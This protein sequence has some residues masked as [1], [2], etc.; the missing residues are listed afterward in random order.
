MKRFIF[1][2][3]LLWLIV[4]FG[5]CARAQMFRVDP[6]SVTTTS[7]SAPIG[8]YPTLYA[9]PGSQVSICT[10]AACTLPATTYTSFTGAVACPVNAQVTLAGS[11]VCT[12]FTG[13]QGQFGFFLAANSGGYW[14]TITVPNGTR[15]GPYPLSPSNTAGVTNLAAGT[16]ISIS[17]STGSITV[18]NAGVTSLGGSTGALNLSGGSGISI[19]GLTVTNT[20][21]TSLDGSA[22]ALNLVAGAGISVSG[23]SISN[24]GVV[25]FN[26]RTGAVSP[27]AGDYAVSTGGTGATGFSSNGLLYG[28]GSAPIQATT[29]GLTYQVAQVSGS[30]APVF[31]SVQLA[32]SAAVSGVLANAN[33]GTG[34]GGALVGIVR[35]GYPFTAAELSGD[36]STFASNVVTLATVNSTPTSCGTATTTCVLTVNAKG[37]VTASSSVAITGGGGGIVSPSTNGAAFWNGTSLTTTPTGGTGTLCLV[38]TNGGAPTFGACSGSAST[39]WS[40]LTAPSSNLSVSMGAYSTTFTW[41]SSTSSNNLFNLTDGSSNTGTGYM[42]DVNLSSGSAMSPALFA[43]NGNG[44]AVNNSG[45]IVV[46]GTGGIPA[47]TIISGVIAPAR[48]LTAA[49]TNGIGYYDG[50][51]FTTTATGGAG[52]LCLVSVGGATP[53]FSSCAGSASTAWS[54]L[55]NPTGAMSVSMGSNT[56]T[57]T[58]GAATSTANLFN[59]TDT[60]SNTG[61]GYIFSVN[62]ASGSAAAP[63]RF[64]V[65]GNGIAINNSGNIVALGTGGDWNGAVIGSSYGGAGTVHGIMQANGSGVVSAVTI[66]TGLT[67]S[68]GTLS[69]SGT[70]GV[71]GSNT[72]VQ[73]NNSGSCGASST[74][75]Y[76][77][78]TDYLGI[79]TGAS[80]SG[81]TIDRSTVTN[82]SQIQWTVSGNGNAS[83]AWLVGNDLSGLFGITAGNT[84]L[85]GLK[86]D[87]GGAV[88]VSTGS[89]NGQLSIDRAS[90]SYTGEILFTSAGSAY[91]NAG[92]IAFGTSQ[93]VLN[94]LNSNTSSGPLIVDGNGITVNPS[95]VVGQGS[96]YLA[97]LTIVQSG[98]PNADFLDLKYGS[99]VN[100]KIDSNGGLTAYNCCIASQSNPTRVAGTIYHNTSGKPL[101][102][103][104]TVSGVGS[105]SLCRFYTDSSSS[106]T[107]DVVEVVTPI[108]GGEVP[109]TFIVLPGN[110][111]RSDAL[112]EFSITVWTEWQ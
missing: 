3:L 80:N 23:L 46:V 54:A 20:G 29:A 90:P 50:T 66:G 112:G 28:N 56:S 19:S 104:I 98:V 68:G 109:V 45:D 85:E 32:Q 73:Y 9:V 58:Y 111:Y 10:D 107:T 86:V 5:P 22:G 42:L 64:A 61:T 48:L 53:S 71:C 77:T 15:Y 75:T 67:L 102:V 43:V 49:N 8:S 84:N 65:N 92:N 108:G 94:P 44:V 6:Q 55:S 38:S 103:T 110:Y 7:G 96:A 105:G 72:Q 99:T 16:G 27:Q 24:T 33:G 26:G 17:S 51:H 37:L 31:G 69:T 101:F 41:N 83:G 13:P 14:Y 39:A 60:S 47:A 89:T 93:F 88:Y 21:V 35:G 34:T 95:I 36:A 79:G 59:L 70:S 62:L 52:T 106:P 87:S 40:G 97:G 78:Y 11:S 30:G 82:V 81:I 76:S 25:S 18:T 74:F 63:A 100:A 57:F 91:V 1:P 12:A 2:L 4:G